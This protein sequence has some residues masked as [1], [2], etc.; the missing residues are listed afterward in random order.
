MLADDDENY[1]NNTNMNDDDTLHTTGRR[2]TNE[3]RSEST[4]HF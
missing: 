4:T 3:E 1:I 2:Y